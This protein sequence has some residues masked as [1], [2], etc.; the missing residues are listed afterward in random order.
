MVCAGITE[1]DSQ[2]SLV[3]QPSLSELQP[4][5]VLS[6]PFDDNSVVSTDD[7]VEGKSLQSGEAIEDDNVFMEEPPPAITDTSASNTDTGTADHERV[8]GEDDEMLAE[9]SSNSALDGA[10]TVGGVRSPEIPIQTSS[11]QTD[12]QES[13]MTDVECGGGGGGGDSV[14]DS[15]PSSDDSGEESMLQG[16]SNSSETVP[17]GGSSSASCPTP[18]QQTNL[19]HDHSYFSANQHRETITDQS[20]ATSTPTDH[21]YCSTERS[22][23]PFLAAPQSLQSD[24]DSRQVHKLRSKLS[25]DVQDHNYCRLS[26]SPSPSETAMKCASDSKEGSQELLFSHDEEPDERI[27]AASVATQTD[28][29]ISSDRS[30]STHLQQLSLPQSVEASLGSIIDSLQ[31][32]QDLSTSALLRA[33]QQLIRGLSVVSERIEAKLLSDN[34]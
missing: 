13:E 17:G 7:G 1:E 24:S 32:Q 33:Q 15:N 19:E 14:C 8:F 28:V 27:S 26:P 31:A 5:V 22:S 25:S 4:A 11:S 21:I 9:A 12:Q 20:A 29:N 30:M 18:L 2:L 23:A 34:L 6:S 16:D 10:P 3:S